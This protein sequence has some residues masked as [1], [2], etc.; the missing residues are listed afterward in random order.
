MEEHLVLFLGRRTLPVAA[1]TIIAPHAALGV[2]KS[3]EVGVVGH[4]EYPVGSL[5]ST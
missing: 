5:N 1:I 2:K 3:G 4:D